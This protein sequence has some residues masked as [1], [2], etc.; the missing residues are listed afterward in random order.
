MVRGKSGFQ[1]IIWAVRNVLNQSLRWLFYDLKGSNDGSGPIS[2][3]Q[4]FVKVVKP[5]STVMPSV[6]IP[7]FDDNFNDEDYEPATE[8]LEWLTLSMCGSP[9]VQK[10]DKVDQ[11]LSRYRMP[12]LI[13]ETQENGPSNT[14]DLVSFYWHGLIPRSFIQSMLLITLKAS[15]D[16][17]FAFSA[18]GFDGSA[19]AFLQRKDSTL[20]WEYDR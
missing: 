1:R 20:T 18:G 19:Y 7:D 6:V 10:D 17:W 14:K 8:I 16:D 13:S 11:Y 4:P 9:R 2:I 15:G 5:D 12:K 3:H